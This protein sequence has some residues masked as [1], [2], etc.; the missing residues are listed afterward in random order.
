[1]EQSVIKIKDQDSPFLFNQITNS[2]FL[3]FICIRLLDFQHRIMGQKSSFDIFCVTTSVGGTVIGTVRSA[4]WAFTPQDSGIL[5]YNL[6][7][8]A[9]RTIGANETTSSITGY[10]VVDRT[11]NNAAIIHTYGTGFGRR[12]SLEMRSDIAAATTGPVIGSR[13]VLA[14]SLNSGDN[15]VD[16][17]IVWVSGLDS[18]VILPATTMAPI[19][20][21][22]RLFAPPS[23]SGFMGILVRNASSVEIENYSVTL[24]LNTT[25]TANS[26]RN[27]QNFNQAIAATRSAATTAGFLNAET[28]P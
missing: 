1:L 3:H 17:D 27:G 7:G 21:E 19:L 20:P 4:S 28:N 5:V 11:N 8:R 10:V 16:H 24:S 22:V 14:G 25:L 12:N 2:F 13:T 26:Y 23:L 6:S 18:E 15:P 9:A